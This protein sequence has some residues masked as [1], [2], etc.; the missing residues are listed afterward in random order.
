[1]M[2]T[3]QKNVDLKKKEKKRNSNSMES[4]KHG[5]PRVYANILFL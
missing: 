4:T 3:E 5:I 2:G 1:M